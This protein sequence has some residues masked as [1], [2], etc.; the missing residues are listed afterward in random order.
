MEALNQM[1]DDTRTKTWIL[2]LGLIGTVLDSLQTWVL[3]MMNYID[4]GIRAL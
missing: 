2:K 4:D 3:K 1:D